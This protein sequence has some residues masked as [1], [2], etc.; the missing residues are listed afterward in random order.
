MKF[1]IN[2][3]PR[4]KIND[5][6]IIGNQYVIAESLRQRLELKSGDM[7]DGTI[8]RRDVGELTYGYGELGFIYAE[9]EPQ[10]VMRDEAN[11]V[12]L[13]Y[14]INEGD[15]WK[16]GEIRVNIEGEPH[17]MRETTML[18]LIDLREGDFIDRRTLE[19]NTL[20]L[21]RSQL[22]ETN[23]QIADPPDI[24]VVPR[25]EADDLLGY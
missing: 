21:E 17:L 7:F 14:K 25:D 10:T 16:I 13:I 20:R 23:P 4:F 22:L 6:Q 18:N 12:D 2:E 11:E 24:K 19:L 3:G 15:R 1:V 5:V 8:M 9:V